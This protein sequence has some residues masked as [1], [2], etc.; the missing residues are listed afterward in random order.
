[1]GYADGTSNQ[2]KSSATKPFPKKPVV[3][4]VAMARVADDWMSHVVEVPSD[5]MTPSG[6]GRYFDQRITAVRI[7]A[8]GEGDFP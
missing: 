1:M 7:L 2:Q 5:L 6:L 4:A 3:T 8:G